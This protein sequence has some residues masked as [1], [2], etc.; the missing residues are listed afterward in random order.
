MKRMMLLALHGVNAGMQS[1]YC[2][3][4]LCEY[5]QYV[6]VK[7]MYSE[8]LTPPICS[9]SCDAVPDVLPV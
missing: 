7:A 5:K 2:A 4:P 3:M 1:K 9:L 8:S 6:D